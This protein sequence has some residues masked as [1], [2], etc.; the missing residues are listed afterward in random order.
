MTKNLPCG[1]EQE[2]FQE[3]PQGNPTLLCTILRAPLKKWMEK[4]VG[5]G[6]EGDPK[7]IKLLFIQRARGEG[8]LGSPFCYPNH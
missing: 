2:I 4:G 3:Q 7:P 5:K 1:T 6:K 8:Y